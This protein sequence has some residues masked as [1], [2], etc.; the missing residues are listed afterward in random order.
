M[1]R[2]VYKSA[3]DDIIPDSQLLD[4]I[5]ANSK[6]K[7]NRY[8]AFIR[9]GSVAAAF[10]ILIGTLTIYPKIKDNLTNDEAVPKVVL[11]QEVSTNST[12]EASTASPEVLPTPSAETS[13]ETHIEN[14]QPKAT[15]Q[16]TKTATPPDEA[17]TSSPSP[18]IGDGNAIQSDTTN[19]VTQEPTPQNIP[20]IT[21][22]SVQEE[23]IPEEPTADIAPAIMQYENPEP[24]FEDKSMY[25]APSGSSGG[26]SSGGSS[27]AKSVSVVISEEN[28][29]T[30][31]DEAFAS[32]F[33]EEFL[34]S[35]SIKIEY[36]E[37]Y[38][39]TR[40]NEEISKTVKITNDGTLQK[41][42]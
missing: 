19:A 1:F 23:Q 30:L 22:P 38:I 6:P 29:I 31:A 34:S 36:N 4:K 42:Y 37:E 28:A 33:G 18:T 35:T 26:G 15:E 2:D 39:I 12:N 3:N 27:R 7:K 11:N 24:V 40:Y 9:Y 32:D 20:V 5:L 10:F 41:Q 25:A 14:V 8:T 21:E 16:T 17:V 13:V